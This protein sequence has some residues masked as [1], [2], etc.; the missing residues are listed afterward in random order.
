MGVERDGEEVGLHVS[1]K[2]GNEKRKERGAGTL[3]RTMHLCYE[4]FR[5][6]FAK[7]YGWWLLA[8]A[9]DSAEM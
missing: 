3:F 6:I 2:M 4:N 8:V 5:N 9:S 7:H 1:K